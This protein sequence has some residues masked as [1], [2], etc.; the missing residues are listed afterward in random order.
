MIMKAVSQ[1]HFVFFTIISMI[2]SL[3]IHPARAATF[4]GAG[5]E[6]DGVYAGGFGVTWDGEAREEL[7]RILSK[8]PMT[9]ER[10]FILPLENKN[11]NTFTLEGKVSVVSRIGGDKVER[12]RVKSLKFIKRKGEW[13]VDSKSLEKA[14][15]SEKKK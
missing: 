1:A 9:F 13:Y 4:A 15:K 12:A 5:V 14:L 6:V 10:T 3:A 7:V 11:A 8:R 2:V